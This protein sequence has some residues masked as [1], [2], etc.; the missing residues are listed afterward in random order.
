M[1]LLLRQFTHHYTFPAGIIIVLI[2]GPNQL[3]QRYLEILA[4]VTLRLKDAEVREA[5]L[6]AATAEETV[7]VLSEAGR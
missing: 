3:Q 7:R 4:G 2:A 5:V 6:A 1:L